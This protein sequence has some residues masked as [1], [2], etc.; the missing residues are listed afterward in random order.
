M[1]RV[2]RVRS[3]TLRAAAALL[4]LVATNLILHQR[5]EL[6]FSQ[7]RIK[8][9]LDAVLDALLAAGACPGVRA[10]S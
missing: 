1:I 10:T 8:A 2:T 4:A 7:A 5:R 3:R 9:G 6:G